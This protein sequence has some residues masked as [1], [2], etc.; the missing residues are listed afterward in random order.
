MNHDKMT[1]VIASFVIAGALAGVASAIVLQQA[2]A[3]RHHHVF[4]LGTPG[5]SVD[6]ANG[7]KGANGANGLSAPGFNGPSSNGSNGTSANGNNTNGAN[8]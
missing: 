3:F 1:L 7:V 4:V 5:S 2:L 6:G 8:G